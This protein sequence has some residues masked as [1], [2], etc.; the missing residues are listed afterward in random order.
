MEF[1][2]GHPSVFLYPLVQDDLYFS[3]LYEHLAA[4]DVNDLVYCLFSVHNN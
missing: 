3:V 4:V 1:L 2:E